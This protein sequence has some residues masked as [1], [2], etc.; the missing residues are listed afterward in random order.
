M[1][2]LINHSADGTGHFVALVAVQSG[3]PV[4]QPQQ[5]SLD[6]VS[7]PLPQR[8]HGRGDLGHA[9]GGQIRSNLGGDDAAGSLGIGRGGPGRRFALHPIHIDD[10]HTGQSGDGGVD[11]ARHAEITHHQR[12]SEFVAGG[13][14][15]CM[16]DV[17]QGHHRPDRTGAA[18]RQ[19]GC[20]QR[21]RQL[22][23]CH[24]LGVDALLG[25]DL[26]QPLRPG[27]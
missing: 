15:Q 14:G 2:Q 9:L 1:Q 20:R 19:V 23:E 10:R 27:Q 21:S 12:L 25:D 7:G 11:I 3:Q 26:R 22:I 16:V 17:S 6:N 13:C 5:L 8:R 4:I 24:R 18:D